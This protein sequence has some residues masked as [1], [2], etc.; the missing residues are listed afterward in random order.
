[1][2]TLEILSTGP[3]ASVQ[4]LGRPGLAHLGVTCSGAADR[5]SHA[6]A[7]RL[8]ANPADWATIEITLGGF[9]ARVYGGS[10]DVA[11]TGAECP[12]RVDRTPFGPN[13]VRRVH[14]GEV[15][16]VEPASR[17]LRGYL[18]VRGG[19]A[20]DP[21][22]GSRSH[23]TLSGI[24]PPV[25]RPGDVLPIGAPAPDFPRLEQAPVSP[26]TEG[27]VTVRVVPGPHDEWFTDPDALVR[28]DWTLS[29]RSDR[30]GIR[31]LGRPLEHRRP[32]QQLPSE[33]LTRGAVQV[34]P[35]GRPVIL[36]ADHPV[37]GGY[38]VIGVLADADTDTAAQLRPGQPVRLRWTRARIATRTRPSW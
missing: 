26:L 6:L 28:T 27:P 16:T 10:V 4:D 3:L 8:V 21:V 31:L 35:N 2:T 11:F 33:G 9:S 22:L 24:G 29:D 19:V 25:L 14:H 15:I 18:A 37:T 5:R 32:E 36:A 23:D 1:M 20:V 34:P 13:S 7:N 17:G 12:T 30:V 38:P